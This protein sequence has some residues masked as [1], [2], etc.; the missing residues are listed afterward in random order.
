[1]GTRTAPAITGAVTKVISSLYLID[2]SGDQYSEAIVTA[3]APTAVQFEALA[4]AYQ[5][6]SQASLWKAVS[7]SIWEGDKDPDN[8]DVGQ[9]NSVKDGVNLLWRNLTTLKTQAPRL[10]APVANT[11][12]GNQDIPLLTADPEFTGLITALTAILSGYNLESAQYT[13]R[14]ERSNN[15]KIKA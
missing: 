2:A 5:V 8:G 6:A 14:K 1:M 9:R 11:M 7:M 13:E 4:A 15:P 10:V 3:T 12:Q